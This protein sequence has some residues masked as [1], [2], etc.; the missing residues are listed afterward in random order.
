MASQAGK[1]AELPA[2]EIARRQA[3]VEIRGR[4]ISEGPSR[5]AWLNIAGPLGALI[6]GV[7][8][9]AF[10]ISPIS[11]I[12]WAQRMDLGFSGITRNSVALQDGGLMS[13][14]ITGG[15]PG[16]DPVLLIH[17]LGPNAGLVWRSV[18]EPLSEGHYKVVAPDLMGFGSSDHSQKTCSIAYEAGA[19]AQLV[20]QL[21]LRHVNVIGW[22]VG[23]DVALYYAEVH[24]Q[25]VERLILVSGGMFGREGANVLRKGM[26]PGNAQEMEQQ[27]DESF[28]D[29]PPMPSFMYE[30]MMASLAADLPAQTDM[31]DSVPKDEARIRARMG[32]IFNTL[33]VVLWGG[34]D[35]YYSP[36][37]GAALHAMM[38]GSASIVFKTSGHY[39]QLEHP[40]DFANTMLFIMKQTEG[41]Q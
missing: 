24:P 3:E 30:R 28:F 14:Y 31:L 18:M 38:P 22:D 15:Y 23:A 4:I 26:L 27:V 40:K 5:H 29:L 21:G 39:P 11:V 36:H 17:G 25:N 32:R 34:K 7:F 9:A 16:M 8:A 20:K 2:E 41:G 33:T 6:L 35:P 10:Y 19:I 37:R 13:Y 12:R 1:S